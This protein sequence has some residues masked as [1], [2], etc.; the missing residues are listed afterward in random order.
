MSSP[1]TALG[2]SRF[3][4]HWLLLTFCIVGIALVVAAGI[5]ATHWPFTREVI[6]KDLAQVSASAVRIQ[7]FQSTYFPPGCILEG[8]SFNLPAGTSKKSQVRIQKLIIRGSYTGMLTVPKRL[9]QIVAEG[10]R[11]R[12][13]P[14]GKNENLTAGAQSGNNKKRPVRIE[15][16][17]ADGAI[18]ELDSAETPPLVFAFHQ[19]QLNSFAADQ[20][21]SFHVVFDNPK[22]PG[23]VE[24]TGR[25]SAWQSKAMGN[26]RV[27]GKYIL[28]KGNL[29]IFKGIAGTLASKGD[30]NGELQRIEVKGTT[31]MPN[32]EVTES[33]HSMPLFTSFAALVN[34]LTGDTSV[35]G[36]QAQLEKTRITG[37]GS[38]AGNGEKAVVLNVPTGE[39]RIEDLVMLFAKAPH[40]AIVGPIHFKARTSLPPEHRKFVERVLLEGDFDIPEAH[41]T[42][43]KTQGHVDQLSE[44]SR[45]EDADDNDPGNVVAQLKGHV[46]LKNATATFTDS[47]FSVPGAVA[48]LHG[49]YNLTNHKINFQGTLKMEAKL[50][51]ATTGIKSLFARFLNHRFETKDAG[52]TLPVTVTGTYEH[53]VFHADLDKKKK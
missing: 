38:V 18:L 21:T 28:S 43:A 40:S 8:V 26:I 41:F 2:S 6:E 15:D 4:K 37:T 1:V 53:P 42:S 17:R 5:L 34:G 29:G 14:L 9:Q 20:G 31:V 32:F 10:L 19:L 27:D 30:F 12:I 35:S 22:P 50:S 7:S 25:M 45:G 49:T 39:G 13:L 33:R 11:I 51:Q 24:A 16:I 48:L 52:A 23:L 47:T 36:I 3:R 44:H 46:A